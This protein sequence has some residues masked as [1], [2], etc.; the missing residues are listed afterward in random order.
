MATGPMVCECHQPWAA[1]PRFQMYRYSLIYFN[2]GPI[3]GSDILY[4]LG[5]ESVRDILVIMMLLKM[6]KT[7]RHIFSLDKD[8]NASEYMGFT[9]PLGAWDGQRYFIVALPEPSI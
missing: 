5:H 6:A 8:Q 3:F 7:Q 4:L 1:L 2:H 9:L